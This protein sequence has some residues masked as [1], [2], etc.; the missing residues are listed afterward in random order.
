MITEVAQ[1]TNLSHMQWMKKQTKK[2][3]LNV[4]FVI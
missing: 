2:F 3:R 4:Y 1:A